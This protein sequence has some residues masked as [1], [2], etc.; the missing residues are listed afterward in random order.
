MAKPGPLLTK[1]PPSRSKSQNTQTESTSNHPDD[2]VPR[3]FHLPQGSLSHLVT[4]A[5]VRNAS[6][7][8]CRLG[9]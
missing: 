3:F 1:C 9:G 2:K 6:K 7:C 4:V 5:G 8:L